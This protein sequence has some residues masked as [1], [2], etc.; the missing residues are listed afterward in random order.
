MR[1]QCNIPTKNI[2]GRFYLYLCNRCLV[3]IWGFTHFRNE[4]KMVVHAFVCPL[5]ICDSRGKAEKCTLN[6]I[7][8]AASY[9]VSGA[10]FMRTLDAYTPA[11]QT[12]DTDSLFTCILLNLKRILIWLSVWASCLS[13]MIHVKQRAQCSTPSEH[14]EL[15]MRTDAC[16]PMATSSSINFEVFQLFPSAVPWSYLLKWRRVRKSAQQSESAAKFIRT[17]RAFTMIAKMRCISKKKPAHNNE[18]G[19][20]DD[21]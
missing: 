8:T 10:H 3:N 4:E 20:C 15:H 11:T 12:H 13:A 17:S 6:T 7:D 14:I 5:P 1:G 18:L 16:E 19:Q 9:R 2:I 21:I